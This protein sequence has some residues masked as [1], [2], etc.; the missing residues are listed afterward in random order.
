VSLRRGGIVPLPFH[1]LPTAMYY[2]PMCDLVSKKTIGLICGIPGGLRH[3]FEDAQSCPF[4][5]SLDLY[6]TRPRSSPRGL[7]SNSINDKPSFLAA[8]T[9]DLATIIPIYDFNSHSQNILIK[10]SKV[11]FSSLQQ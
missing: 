5:S 6:S 7:I 3:P 10:P 9:P 4:D 11:S 8:K 1:N 2:R